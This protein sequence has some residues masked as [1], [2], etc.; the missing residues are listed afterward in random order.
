MTETSDILPTCPLF[1]AVVQRVLDGA[2]P[3]AALTDPHAEGCPPCRETAAAVRVLLAALKS[4]TPIVPPAHFAERVVPVV[5]ADRRRRAEFRR[6][7]RIAVASLAASIL[8]AFLTTDFRPVS[9]PTAFR[10]V[11]PVPQ[12]QPTPPSVT[13]SFAD[14]GSAVFSLTRRAADESLSPARNLFA[15]LDVPRPTP[16]PVHADIKPT[17]SSP[18]EP[19]TNTAKRALNLFIRDI[20]GLAAIPQQKS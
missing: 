12:N 1:E 4:P 3:I 8:V 13:K 10:S 16:T 2:L 17:S 18:V 6:S 7:V 5:V 14:A 19:I 9:Q 11:E 20:G 15:G